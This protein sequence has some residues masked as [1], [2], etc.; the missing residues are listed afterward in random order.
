VIK[1]GGQAS[2]DYFKVDQIDKKMKIFY[3]IHGD[4]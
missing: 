3:K 1:T 2:I 4:T